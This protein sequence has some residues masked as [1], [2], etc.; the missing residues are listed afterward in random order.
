MSPSGQKYGRTKRRGGGGGGGVESGRSVPNPNAGAVALLGV[1][2]SQRRT[3]SFAK[4][5]S[6]S[7]TT[8]NYSEA[9]FYLNS[10]YQTDGVTNAVGFSKYMAFF[11][12]C[13]VVGG[14][15]RLS[16]TVNNAQPCLCGLV[17]TTNTT[18]LGS[19]S[20]AI[21]NGMCQWDRINS[22][23]DTKTFTQRVNTSKFLTKP[24]VLDDPQLFCTSGALPGQV[25]VGH[26]F[27]SNDGASTASLNYTLEVLLECVFTDPIPFT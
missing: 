2:R 26:V 11:S 22:H 27:I 10:G 25:I 14:A 4:T 20:A 12:K 8:L 13:F 9:T 18:S 24:K 5:A 17:V 1:A 3:L 7:V 19:G 16:V 21:E 23:P 6:V 15:A